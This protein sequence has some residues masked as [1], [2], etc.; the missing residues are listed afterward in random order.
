[1]MG[2]GVMTRR[3]KLVHMLLRTYMTMW[4]EK[5]LLERR[6]R[7][8][9]V[10]LRRAVE[11]M[12]VTLW[13][14]LWR[15]LGRPL[16]GTVVKGSWWAIHKRSWRT[17]ELGMSIWKLRLKRLKR[18]GPRRLE[19]GWR[20][21]MLIIRILG[22]TLRIKA[23]LLLLERSLLRRS[24]HLGLMLWRKKRRWLRPWVLAVWLG[25]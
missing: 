24:L 5:G 12:R 20:R 10:W 23:W 3:L 1:M 16:H 18:L 4:L 11:I 7:A 17:L 25:V 22:H 8:C 9:T 14:A 13:R 6:W 15:S 2:W 19:L 21:K